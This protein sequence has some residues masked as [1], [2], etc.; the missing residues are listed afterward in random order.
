[1]QN[2]E[3]ATNRGDTKLYLL[4]KEN[5]SEVELYSKTYI[6]VLL[7]ILFVVFL[8]LG[9]ILILGLIFVYYFCC[10]VFSKMFGEP[11]EAELTKLSL[12]LKPFEQNGIN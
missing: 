5:I 10:W 4:S 1:M 6:W 9:F 7:A 2:Q 3:I 11:K 12:Q 8:F